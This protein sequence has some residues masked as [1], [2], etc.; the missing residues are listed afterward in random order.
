MEHHNVLKILFFSVARR[1]Y[2]GNL[3]PKKEILQVLEREN[4]QIVFV[5]LA[6]GYTEFHCSVVKQCKQIFVTLDFSQVF[7]ISNTVSL[8][9]HIGKSTSHI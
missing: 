9:S 1:F 5:R 8:K 4:T 3:S 2:W 7:C 6:C